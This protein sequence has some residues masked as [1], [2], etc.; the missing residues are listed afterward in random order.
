LPKATRSG[1][2]GVFS[3]AALSGKG[4]NKARAWSSKAWSSL[5]A[6]ADVPANNATL[7]NDAAA[8]E[9]INHVNLRIASLLKN[10]D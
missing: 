8:A 2:S 10:P 6:P 4:L 9:E 7:H 1:V 3:K 5:A